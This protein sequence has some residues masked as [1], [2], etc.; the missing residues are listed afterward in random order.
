[1]TPT[2]SMFYLRNNSL[3]YTIFLG[4]LALISTSEILRKFK[5]FFYLRFGKLRHSMARTFNMS[6]LV[7]GVCIVLAFCAKPKVFWVNTR[8]VIASM[9]YANTFRNRTNVENIRGNMSPY[10]YS[11]VAPSSDLAVSRS[12]F[13][14]CPQPASFRDLHLFPEPF[15]KAGR[16]SLRFQVL[17]SKFRS[18]SNHSLLCHAS[19]CFSNAGASSFRGRIFSMGGQP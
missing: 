14:C 12:S 11:S 3:A 17:R 1:M 19:D 18:L 2:C 5:Y 8:R 16:K 9:A 4:Y 10:R 15:R 6:P 7:H 13:G